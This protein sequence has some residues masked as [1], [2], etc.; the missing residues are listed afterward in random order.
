[1]SEI[2]TYSVA[3][4]NAYI[5]NLLEN[6]A[7]LQAVWV[8][9]EVSNMKRAASGHWYFTIKDAQS[10]LKCVMFRNHAE[11]QSIEPND[12]EAIRVHGKIS[13]YEQRGEYQIYADEVQL[14]GGVGDLYQ[15]FEELKRKLAEE[16]LFDSERKRPLPEFPMRI[17]VVTSPDAAAFRDIQNVLAR[18][19]PMAQVILAPTM[20]Q[21]FEAPPLIVRAIESL[22]KFNA[23]DVI[24]VCRGGGSIEDL[25]AF[26]D[27]KVART[28]AAS[29]IPIVSGVGH[30]T[31]FT[32]ADFVA[33]LRAPTPSAAAELATPNLDDLRIDVDYLDGE[34]TSLLE[35]SFADKYTLIEN[36]NQTLRRISPE[37]TLREYRQRIDDTAERI[38][39]THL[40]HLSLLR[41]RL[42]GQ[43]KALN[44]AN[45]DALLQRGYAI[46]LRSDDDKM[47]MN[48]ADAPPGTRLTIRLKNG[49]LKARTEDEHTHA[50][51]KRTL[52]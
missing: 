36:A 4:I 14:A 5:R 25:W 30:E 33:D 11:R 13:V 16:G 52:F 28:I 23:A 29:A 15:R 50:Q 26:N 32:I 38:H 35:K 1:M 39:N 24:L 10:Q 19:F 6:D 43:V 49:E 22:N 20:V 40:R 21:G 12:G 17:G 48:A 9:G 3:A 46:V 34:L 37:R 51:Y 45:P 31:D 41:E 7:P 47:L 42:A 27:E 8:E 2:Y 18:R 44:A